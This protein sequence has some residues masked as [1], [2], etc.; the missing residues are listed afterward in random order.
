MLTEGKKAPKTKVLDA[1]GAAVS[2]S[3]YAGKMVVLYFYPKDDTQGCTVEAK[4]FRDYMAKFKKL[5]V[6]VIGVS[7]DSTQ[8]HEKFCNK[9]DLNFSLWSDEEH[10]LMDAFGVWQLKKFMGREFMGTVRSTF[11]IDKKGTIIKVFP[12]VTVKDHAKE[13]Y[14]FVSSL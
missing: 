13:V 9:Y 12:K 3:D 4:D 6:V 2:L 10:K 5:G 8:S 11:V 7:K 14:T 1:E